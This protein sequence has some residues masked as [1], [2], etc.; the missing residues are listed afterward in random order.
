[1]VE[2]LERQELRPL[3]AAVDAPRDDGQHRGLDVRGLEAR[4]ERRALGIRS[5]FARGTAIVHGTRSVAPFRI[6]T[7][8]APPSAAGARGRSGTVADTTT[9]HRGS[10]PQP[11]D[12]RTDVDDDVGRIRGSRL[13]RDVERATADV[14]Q[15]HAAG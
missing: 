10:G 2:L 12:P 6:F 1:M 8:S 3:G 13:D 5:R 4:L 15:R 14:P 9:S 7:R 11:R